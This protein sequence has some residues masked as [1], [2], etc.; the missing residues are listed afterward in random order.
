MKDRKPKT[1]DELEEELCNHCSLDEKARGVHNYGRGPVFCWD[2]C[3]C[4]IAYDSYVDAFNNGEI[5]DEEEI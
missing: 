5:E 1:C 3:Y 2:S 4:K